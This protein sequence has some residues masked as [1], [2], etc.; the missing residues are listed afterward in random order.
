MPP[1]LLLVDDEPAILESLSRLLS[2]Y[3][4]RTATSGR[5]AL[6]VLEREPIAACLV[7][8][9]LPDLDGFDLL[10]RARET[11]PGVQVVLMSG[12]PSFDAALQ[13]LRAGAADFLAKPFTRA[14]VQRAVQRALQ[15]DRAGD[16]RDAAEPAAAPHAASAAPPALVG[17][18]QAM[19]QVQDLIDR[20]GPSDATV[21]VHGESGTGKEVV[22]AALHARSS[23]KRGP[24][25]KVNC[26]AIP[27]TLL[28]SELFG[29]ERGAFT[30]AVRAKKGRFEL[31]HGGTI[32]LD[33]IGDMSP[34]TQTK[35]LRVL[36]EGEIDR[37]GGTRTQNVDVRVLAATNV[38]L[39][40]A[41]AERRFREDLY[42][43][44]RVIEIRLPPLRE[45]KEDI[46]LLAEHFVRRYAAK[47]RKAIAALEPDALAML[48]DHDWP[49]NV[50]ELENAIE[51]AVVLAQG[52]RIACGDLAPDLQKDGA[53]AFVTFT[54]GTTIAEMERRMLA[55]TLRFTD[56]DKTRAAA[57]LGITSR[58]IYRKLEQRRRELQGG[59][60][61]G[62]AAD[63][64][65]RAVQESAADA[66]DARWLE[67]PAAARPGRLDS[68]G[69]P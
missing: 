4:L 25:I 35:V 32:F 8:V 12:H 33:E 63:A 46:P 66:P 61:G 55:E 5:A 7:D 27:D 41:I 49:G 69:G 65:E 51:R 39:E 17:C 60:S 22:A 23:R 59:A 64:L 43:R 31:A 58:T 15:R 47:A 18:S 40:R 1:V 29:H 14:D 36:Q 52:A 11:S 10:R 26:A 68:D 30:G 13:A 37:V 34:A 38:D 62:A 56:G 16:G 45:R 44:L 6:H 20:V 19:R 21:L 50:R 48:L 9:R 24:Y 53:R 28:E 54:V 42:Y 2:D 3:D 67:S 57:M